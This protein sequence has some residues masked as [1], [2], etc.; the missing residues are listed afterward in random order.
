[1]KMPIVNLI[2]TVSHRAATI[3][4]ADRRTHAQYLILLNKMNKNFIVK[5]MNIALKQVAVNLKNVFPQMNAFK[6][7]HYL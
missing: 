7:M 6:F 5:L 1:M 2:M 4:I 3:L